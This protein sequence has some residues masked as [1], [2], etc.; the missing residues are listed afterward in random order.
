MVRT[1][2]FSFGIIA[3]S[4]FSLLTG[5]SA[6]ATGYNSE[7]NKPSYWGTNCVKTEMNGNVT[8][9][10]ATGNNIIK[11]VVKGGT[12][13]AVYTS[14]NYT[15]L[16]APTNP[17][18]GKPY[19]ISHVIVCYGQ[20]AST[21]NTP[22]VQG[23][24]TTTPPKQAISSTSTTKRAPQVLCSTTG[25]GA[26]TPTVIPETG[27]KENNYALFAGLVLSALTYAFALRRQEQ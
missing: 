26:V 21:P 1:K 10:T 15:N 8:T 18:S 11:V 19:G 12:E 20:T 17:R 2:L 27:A 14:G 16:T 4:V 24:Q 3:A 9:Y 23:T 25:K 5:V 7:L 6:S 22:A 13:N